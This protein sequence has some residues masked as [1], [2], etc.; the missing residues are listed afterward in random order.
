MFTHFKGLN[1]NLFGIN[2][3]LFL[4]GNRLGIS[5]VTVKYI[6]MVG[7]AAKVRFEGTLSLCLVLIL[8]NRICQ[9]QQL[10]VLKNA[11]WNIQFSFWISNSHL[12][13]GNRNC[14]PSGRV[15]LGL[16]LCADVLTVG[17][18]WPKSY[19]A[20]NRMS[21]RDWLTFLFSAE[22]VKTFLLSI[23]LSSFQKLLQMNPLNLLIGMRLTKTSCIVSEKLD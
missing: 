5:R 23:T 4:H 10:L 11:L 21:S 9:G 2:K 8:E 1:F 17:G 13:H 19:A 22:I 6:F 7:R 12:Q 15:E 3:D 16:R 14:D 20:G 18:F